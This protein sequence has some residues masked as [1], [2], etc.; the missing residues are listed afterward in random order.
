MKHGC[1][2]EFKVRCL[3]TCNNSYSL[4]INP[5]QTRYLPSLLGHSIEGSEIF[6]LLLPFCKLTE[7]HTPFE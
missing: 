6:L 1:S 4:S 3:V 2:Y 5:V 7:E